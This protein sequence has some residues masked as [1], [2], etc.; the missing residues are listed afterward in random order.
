MGGS[1]GGVIIHNSVMTLNNPM[2]HSALPDAMAKEVDRICSTSSW[3]ETDKWIMAHIY[4][5]ALCN[6]T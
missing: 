5:W 2:V 6:L 3:S 4:S 1:S